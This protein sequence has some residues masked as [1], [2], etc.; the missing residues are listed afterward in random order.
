LIRSDFL[1]VVKGRSKIVGQNA[2]LLPV[3]ESY[4][5]YDLL[6]SSLPN[7]VEIF[8]KAGKQ[9]A[10]NRLAFEPSILDKLGPDPVRD[11]PLSFMGS[12]SADHSERIDFLE[13][14]AANAPLRVWGSGI[15]GV[16]RKSPLHAC[17]QGEA[18][19]R[20]M[21]NVLRRSKITLNKHIDIA[22]GM[23]N[24]MRLY[25]ATGMGALLLTDAQKNLAE[26]FSPGEQVAAYTSP[27]D[28]VRQIKDLLSDE[29]RRARIAAAGQR[30]AIDVQNYRARV[31]ELVSLFENL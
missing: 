7:Y 20:D 18:W 23:A 6:I 1:S 22:A 15:E 2:A 13:Y 16:S 25:E 19:G 27:E 12:L 5:A 21:Y 4:A 29:T 8:R 11:I 31:G 30:Q 28:C 14:V 24:N 17:Y 10:L 26:I 3:N 9:A